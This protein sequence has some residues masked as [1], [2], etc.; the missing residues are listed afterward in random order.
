MVN[1]HS[2]GLFSNSQT[3][4]FTLETLHLNVFQYNLEQPCGICRN[5]QRPFMPSLKEDMTEEAKEVVA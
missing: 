1:L 2:V 4:Q 5:C 3:G